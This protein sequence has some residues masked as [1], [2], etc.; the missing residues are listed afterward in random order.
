MQLQKDPFRNIKKALKNPMKCRASVMFVRVLII[1]LLFIL[2][3]LN[4]YRINETKDITKK[5]SPYISSASVLGNK[6]IVAIGRDRT[7]SLYGCSITPPPL[8]SQTLF[9]TT[10]CPRRCSCGT[11]GGNHIDGIDG[12]SNVICFPHFLITGANKAGT[13]SLYHYLS[14]HPSIRS[15][16]KKELH[17]WT[18]RFS[19]NREKVIKYLNN[20][21]STSLSHYQHSN[22]CF[23]NQEDSDWLLNS[24]LLV[25]GE[26]NN[27][28][29]CINK[30][31]QY[32][33]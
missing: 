1:L 26:V 18:F 22:Q 19:L 4:I 25:T 6:D 24:K 5:Y 28:T 31:T 29:F 7:D 21:S 14:Y 13:S 11:I 20:F 9:N 33:L 3:I 27:I 23:L 12:S 10:W 32:K 16:G 17:Y 30:Q 8:I 2:C 15:A